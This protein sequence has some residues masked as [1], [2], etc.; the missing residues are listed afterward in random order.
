ME[1]DDARRCQNDPD[2]SV[3]DWIRGSGKLATKSTS[4]VGI[5]PYFADSNTISELYL[6][7][8]AIAKIV[9]R[10]WVQSQ[11]DLGLLS[12]QLASLDGCCQTLGLWG[13]VFRG[14]KFETAVRAVPDIS[15][16]VLEALIKIGQ[17]LNQEVRLPIYKEFLDYHGSTDSNQSDL[18]MQL[19]RAS[20]ILE[21]HSQPADGVQSTESTNSDSSKVEISD[22][23]TSEEEIC[24]EP[25]GEGTGAHATRSNQVSRF[26]RILN[27][28]SRL[29]MELCP[30]IDQITLSTTLGHRPQRLQV[31]TIFHVSD[32]AQQWVRQIFDKFEHIDNALAER[33]GEANWQRYHRLRAQTNEDHM[34][35]A[36]QPKSLFRPL[37]DSALGTSIATPTQ[38]AYSLASHSSF[39]SSTADS[40]S[41]RVPKIPGAALLGE[42]FTCEVCGKSISNV[43]NR[44]QWKLHIFADIKPYICTFNDCPDILTAFPSRKLWIDHDFVAHRRTITYSCYL[45]FEKLYDEYEVYDHLQTRHSVNEMH[46]SGKRQTAILKS[47]VVTMQPVEDQIC[48]LCQSSGFQTQRAFGKHLGRHMEQIALLALPIES[49]SDSELY[50]EGFSVSE[51]QS[52][53]LVIENSL[54]KNH[55]FEYDDT[56]END[57]CGQPQVPDISGTDLPTLKVN[58]PKAKAKFSHNTGLMDMLQTELQASERYIP[59]ESS[60]VGGDLTKDDLKRVDSTTARDGANMTISPRISSPP[61]ASQSIETRANP[62]K[63]HIS[64][65]ETRQVEKSKLG[66]Q[67]TSKS[68]DIDPA[69]IQATYDT[70]SEESPESKQWVQ[71]WPA[72]QDQQESPTENQERTP[73]GTI[74]KK[75]TQVQTQPSRGGAQVKGYNGGK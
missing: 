37:E 53:G 35:N 27:V 54:H 30:A 51:E 21:S 22:D 34:A 4:A 11:E 44:T 26:L 28:R 74:P 68:A 64:A 61:M 67:M 25:S 2:Y 65:V 70:E 33:L 29:L 40:G 14:S 18:T 55:V 20:H 15:Q 47:R 56:L 60:H 41:R 5:D 58:D 43:R 72:E 66:T 63:A 57:V 7:C 69:S 48:P 12:Q 31:P 42:A 8:F 23:S 32:A 17:A 10:G 45:C 19:E 13:N 62:A 24:P 73:Q 36:Q 49:E 59:V 6:E 50:E 46:L 1:A 3:A 39:A 75:R 16:N 38:I 52:Q 9:H 71:G